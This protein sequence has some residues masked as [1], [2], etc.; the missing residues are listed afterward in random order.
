MCPWSRTSPAGPGSS[1]ALWPRRSAPFGAGALEV[2]AAQEANLDLF[3]EQTVGPDLACAILSAFQVGVEAGLPPEALLL[4]LYMSGEL[5][6]SIQAMAEHGFFQQVKLHGY[7]A[8]YGGMIRFIGLDQ[9]ERAASYQKVY[10]DIADGGFAD[11]LRNE[12]EAGFP[13]QPFLDD[14]MRGDNPISRA[15][16]RIRD[17]IRLGTDDNTSD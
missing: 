16:K 1:S 2:S 17:M 4:D 13:S 15:E 8:A 7:A 6:R 9:E 5:G 14:M 11:A 3:V 10:Q 12:V